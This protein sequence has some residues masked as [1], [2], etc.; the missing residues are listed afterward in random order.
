MGQTSATNSADVATELPH[1]WSPSEDGTDSVRTVGA[2]TGLPHRDC[3]QLSSNSPTC[4]RGGI[5]DT[6]RASTLDDLLADSRPGCRT[7]DRI[8]SAQLQ[9]SHEASSRRLPWRPL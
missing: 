2:E 6:D 9:S 4:S 1:I 7:S 3:V 5:A 8:R